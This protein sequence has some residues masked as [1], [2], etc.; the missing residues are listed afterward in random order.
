MRAA[1]AIL[2]VAA[3]LGF[4]FAP[5]QAGQSGLPVSEICERHIAEAEKNLDIPSQLLLAIAT[6]ESGVWN[7]ER[8]RSTAWPWTV[9]AR[10]QGRRFASKAEALVN[11]KHFY[12]LGVRN[13]DIGCMQVNLKYHGRAFDSLEEMLDPAH[14]VAYAALLLKSLYR[15]TRSWS[16]AI[17]RYHSWTPRLA[18]VYHNKVKQAWGTARRIAYEDRRLADQRSR[19]ARRAAQAEQ[20]RLRLLAPAG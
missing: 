10:Q 8:A 5:L 9:Y 18:R 2:L 6:V 13:I 16:S 15:D 7:A 3:A 20:K 4:S 14:N 19:Q 11:I 12:N 17:A 1:I